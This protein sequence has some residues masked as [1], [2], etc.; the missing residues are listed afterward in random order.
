MATIT[1]VAKRA[2]VSETTVSHALNGTRRVSAALQERVLAAAA[3]L[4]YQPAAAAR[5]LRTGQTDTLGLLVPDITNSWHPLVARGLMDVTTPQGYHTLLCATDGVVEQEAAFLA[6]LA[7]RRVDGI[8][9]ITFAFAMDVLRRELRGIPTVL[10]G[11]PDQE[12]PDMDYVVFDEVAAARLAVDH[13]AQRGRRRIATITG[14]QVL[15]GARR[16]FQGYREGLAAQGLPYDP[17]LVVEGDYW[18]PSGAHGAARLLEARPRPDAIVAANDLMAL[19]ALGALRQ[20]GIAVPEQ[21]ALIG[22]DDI[23]EAEIAY[24]QLTTVRQPAYEIGRQ[25]GLLLLTRIRCM[26]D[27]VEHEPSAVVRVEPVL[28]LRGTA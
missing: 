23:P 28:V 17:L 4:D 1:D 18:L 8:V 11:L 22:F 15:P 10:T 7:Q 14:P 19:G 9:I 5:S 27:G 26:K 13:L 6:D 25:A 24:P 3:A 20:A 16:R 12:S 21:M 2:N